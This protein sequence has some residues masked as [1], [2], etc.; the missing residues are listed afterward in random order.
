MPRSPA[1]ADD[2]L[3]NIERMIERYR[4]EAIRRLERRTMS[5]WRKMETR[6]AL[7]DFE[8]PLERIH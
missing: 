4:L 3:A 2:R 6:K 1:D 5:L 7:A 8:K